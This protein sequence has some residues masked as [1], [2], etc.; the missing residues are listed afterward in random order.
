MPLQ[1][2]NAVV[3]VLRLLGFVSLSALLFTVILSEAM[4]RHTVFFNFVWTYLLYT[5]V[6]IFSD[7]VQY[8]S[9]TQTEKTLDVGTILITL[10]NSLWFEMRA[11]FSSVNAWATKLR[12][13][14]LLITPYCMGIVPFSQLFDINQT[15]NNLLLKAMDYLELSLVILTCLWDILLVVTFCSYRRIFRR[16]H[17]VNIVTISLLMRLSVFC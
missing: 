8:M 16:V 12:T 11:A 2:I 14:M 13:F 6:M 10:V 9:F 15:R 1:G 3:F 7:V 5:S 4:H 17:M